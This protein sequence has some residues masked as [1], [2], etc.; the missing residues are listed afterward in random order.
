MI[1]ML[2]RKS[3][4]VFIWFWNDVAEVGHLFSTSFYL[5]DGNKYF[6]TQKPWGIGLG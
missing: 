3:K 4:Y 5:A 1:N 6:K 2:Q